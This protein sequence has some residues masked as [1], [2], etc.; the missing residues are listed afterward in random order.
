MNLDLRDC[1]FHGPALP[2]HFVHVE[3]GAVLLRLGLLA[4]DS[5]EPLERG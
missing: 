2:E 5:G 1:T 3:L 4:V